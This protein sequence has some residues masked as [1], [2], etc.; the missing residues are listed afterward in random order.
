MNMDRKLT[1]FSWY[2]YKKSITS[3]AFGGVVS[4][5]TGC[6]INK[7]LELKICDVHVQMKIISVTLMAQLI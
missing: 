2:V 7:M 4:V 5:V 1:D 3:D 6:S